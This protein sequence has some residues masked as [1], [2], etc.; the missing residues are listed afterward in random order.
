M[1]LSKTFHPLL[2][3]GSTKEK[4]GKHPGIDIDIIDNEIKD[5]YYSKQVLHQL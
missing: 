3:T 4:T 1:A 5:I 2:S